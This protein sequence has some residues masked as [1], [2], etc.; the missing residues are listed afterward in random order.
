MEEKIGI[1]INLEV[2]STLSDA[3]QQLEGAKDTNVKD[4]VFLE[5]VKCIKRHKNI[6]CIDLHNHKLLINNEA[7]WL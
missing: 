7:I 5:G 4:Y 6:K 3:W 1:N 2:C